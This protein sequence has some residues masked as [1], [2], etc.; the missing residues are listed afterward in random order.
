MPK[1]DNIF[2]ETDFL[3]SQFL[4]FHFQKPYFTKESFHKT[5]VDIALQAMDGREK[6]KAADIG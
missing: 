1:Q 5:L 3:L 2:Y 4:E 6:K